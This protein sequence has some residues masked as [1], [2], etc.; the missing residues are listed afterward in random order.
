MQDHTDTALLIIALYQQ[1]TLIRSSTV[2]A[3]QVQPEVRIIMIMY[4]CVLT[5]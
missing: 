5:H 3:K 4:I 2:P 1:A